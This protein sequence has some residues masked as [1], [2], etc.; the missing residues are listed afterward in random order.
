MMKG[1]FYSWNDSKEIKATRIWIDWLLSRALTVT[2]FAFMVHTLRASNK[3]NHLGPYHCI[4]N[5]KIATKTHYEKTH[6]HTNNLYVMIAVLSFANH[7]LVSIV[8][9]AFVQH[10][11]LPRAKL[12]RVYILCS[13]FFRAG[14]FEW[15][16]LSI[17]HVFETDSLPMVCLHFPRV[18][19]WNEWMCFRLRNLKG[20]ST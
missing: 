5:T 7:L 2:I 9:S 4:D 6:I 18:H 19:H 13:S 1:I 8:T 10:S 17:F 14:K 12:T 20:V 15:N 3:T 16:F 11:I